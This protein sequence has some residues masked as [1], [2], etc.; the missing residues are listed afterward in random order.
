MPVVLLT[1]SDDRRSRFWARHA[2]GRRRTSP[3]RRS[4]GCST[5]VEESPRGTRRRRRARRRAGNRAQRAGPCR[6]AS[7]SCSTPRSTS[8][9]SPARCARSRS[10]GGPGDALRRARARSRRT[11]SAIAGSRS[12]P[13]RGR[14]KLM[15]HTHTAHARGRRARGARRARASRTSL[16]GAPQGDGHG[17]H[18][19]ADTRAGRRR[20]GRAAVR[21]GVRFGDDVMGTIALSPSRRGAS[22]EDRRFVAIVG[23][24]A[25]RP[26][27]HGRRSSPRRGASRR[28]TR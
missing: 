20:S 9:R 26:A 2:R 4:I 17:L 6:S 8:R 28:P 11:S 16:A 25:R 24:R 27:P 1:A 15:L 19:I 12:S 21:R 13:T 3:R 22:L 7:R 18:L 10:I 5:I 23:A 14:T